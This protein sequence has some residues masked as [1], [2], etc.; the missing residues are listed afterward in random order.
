MPVIR[1]RHLYT[2]RRMIGNRVTSMLFPGMSKLPG[3]DD[4]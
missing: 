1:S 4:I 3:F 2:G